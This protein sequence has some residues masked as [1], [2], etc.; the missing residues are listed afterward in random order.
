M[1]RLIAFLTTL[2]IFIV[3]YRLVYVKLI[4][5]LIKKE[6]DGEESKAESCT[7]TVNHKGDA[8]HEFKE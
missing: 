1:F 8:T 4:I 2:L 5:P 7:T 6:I 3:V